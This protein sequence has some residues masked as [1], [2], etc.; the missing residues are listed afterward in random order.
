MEVFGGL[1]PHTRAARTLVEADYRMK[2]VGMGLR[3]R[4]AGREELH[5]PDQ[6]GARGS[7]RAAVVVHVE[8]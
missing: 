5:E 3:G 2:L 7:G 6:V 8:L 1:D 4:R